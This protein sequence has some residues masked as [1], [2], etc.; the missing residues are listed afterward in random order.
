MSDVAVSTE[1][2]GFHLKGSMVTVMVL[3]LYGDVTATFAE[4][5][6]ATVEQAPQL[7]RQ[8]PVVLNLDKYTGPAGPAELADLVSAC[9]SQALQPIGFRGPAGLAEA[10]ATTGLALLPATAG[11]TRAAREPQVAER[12]DNSASRPEPEAPAPRRSKLVTQPVRSGQQIYAR[13]ADL[14]VMA[15]VS[16]GAEIL[17]DGNIHIYGGLR[18]RALAGV[19]GD[20]AARIFCQR[21]EAQLLSVAGNFILS[22][23]MRDDLRKQPVQVYLD[24]EKLC[25][26]PL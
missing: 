17:A 21:M 25:M 1:E 26:E 12:G 2:C 22:D 3:E 8:S 6:A 10:I 24:G 19:Q 18:G 16:E 15:P 9:R 5:L 23:D 13:D 14:I 11:R 4:Q 7:L 20:T